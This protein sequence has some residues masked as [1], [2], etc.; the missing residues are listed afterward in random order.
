[1]NK[2]SPPKTA[3]YKVSVVGNDPIVVEASSES[4]AIGAAAKQYI[5]V[6][7]YPVDK[8]VAYIQAGGVP[9]KVPAKPK[10][11]Y[12]KKAATPPKVVHHEVT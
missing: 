8:L 12:A 11:P 6:E 2:K 4:E 9:V 1:M 10:R 3:F 7:P 5:D